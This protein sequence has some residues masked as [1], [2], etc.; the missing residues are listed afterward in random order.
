M[1][2]SRRGPV[3]EEQENANSSIPGWQRA[4]SVP[5]HKRPVVV[6]TRNA[7]TAG[8]VND[9]A[10]QKAFLEVPKC[11]IY[12]AKQLREKFDEMCRIL[13]NTDIDWSKRMNAL[14]TL[15]AIIIGGGLDYSDF[16]EE[17][18]DLEVALSNS[19][20]DLR[21]QVCREGCVTVAFYCE[22]L[23]TRMVNLVDSLMPTLIGLLQNS[24]KVMATSGQVALKYIVRYVRSQKLLP[25]LH[26][27]MSSKSKDIRRFVAVLIMMALSTWDNRLIEKNMAIFIDCIKMSVND[28]DSETRTIGRD[29]FMQLDPDYKQQ[30]YKTL[31]PSKQRALSGYL[32]Q[33]S[34]SQSIISERDSLPVSHRSA[35]YA[36]HKTSPSYYTGRSTSDIDPGAARRA[37]SRSRVPPKWGVPP[38]QQVNGSNSAAPVRIPTSQRLASDSRIIPTLR[39]GITTAPPVNVTSTN[40]FAR[41]QPDSILAGSRST[42]PSPKVPSSRLPP[43]TIGS[44]NRLRHQTEDLDDRASVSTTLNFHLFIEIMK[45][46]NF[47]FETVELTTALSCCSSSSISEKKDGLKALSAILLSEKQISSPDLKKIADRLNVLIGE[48]SHKL[49]QPLTDVVITFV[50]LYHHDLG[51]WLNQLIPKLVTKYSNDVLLS[52]QE[53]FSMMLDAVRQNFNPEKQLNAV[54]KFIQDPIR[55]NVT[56]KVK[57]GLLD[58]LHKLMQSMEVWKSMNQSEV[59][60]AINKIFQWANDPKNSG[61]MTLSE[62]IISDMFHLNASDFTSMIATY[63]NDLKDRL[64]AIVRKNNLPSCNMNGSFNIS[65]D[66]RADILETTAQINEFVD[67]RNVL[68]SCVLR[69][70]YQQSTP[71]RDSTE[72]GGMQRA[73]R[74]DAN[75]NLSGYI[76]DAQGFAADLAQQEELIT[77]IGEELSLHNKRNSE[78]MR[79]MAVLSQITRDN[80][81]SLWDKHFKMIFLLLIET[82]KDNDPDIRRM[83]LKL[84]KEIWCYSQAPRF[85]HFAEM[86]LIRVLDACTDEAKFVVSA[87]ED[88]GNVLATHVSSATCRRVLLAVIKSDVGEAKILVAIK[89]LTKVIESLSVEELQ[90]VLNEI[91]PPIVDTYNYENSSIRKESVIC[92][93]AM[94]LIVGEESMAPYLAKLNK[95]KQK[96]IDVYV[97]RMKKPTSS[98]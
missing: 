8:S 42:S 67:Q 20:K 44:S 54:C 4:S 92:L 26:T 28:P 66:T 98:L 53:K 36:L 58:Y 94:I 9:E 6:S 82:L 41:S 34:S 10:F 37:T 81:F 84:L 52:N 2:A 17:L 77:K 59:R 90:S 56:F 39:R 33:S 76:L 57:Y 16:T 62:K 87:A 55:N 73:N 31:D 48:S 49:L 30:L 61:L 78:R 12:S 50:R 83:A 89:M 18:R 93:V 69:S 64:Q 72:S 70:H 80:L 27:A 23:E 96:L 21:S 97:Q 40:N 60:Q 3:S 88:C 74:E 1:L 51:D 75:G 86:A 19:I 35:A 29:M 46:F 15:R 43:R 24:A 63:P 22:R 95:G 32:S 45:N 47:R 91:A 14:K 71:R 68:P 38:L 25:H 5:A 7:G 79:A 11:D 85:N 65:N 13:E